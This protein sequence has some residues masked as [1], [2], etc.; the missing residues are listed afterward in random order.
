MSTMKNESMLDF[1]K[2]KS[3]MEGLK[4]RDFSRWTS[5]EEEG[6][7]IGDLLPLKEFLNMVANG[8]FIDYDGHGKLATDIAESNVYIMPS[9]VFHKN[10]ALKFKFPKWATHVIWFNK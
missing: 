6:E 5:G 1:M 7:I 2:K 10:G 8:C 9:D 3:E 4:F